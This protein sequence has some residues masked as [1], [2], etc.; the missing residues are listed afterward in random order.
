MSR[1]LMKTI[2]VSLT[3]S[4][5][6]AMFVVACTAAAQYADEGGGSGGAD[7]LVSRRGERVAAPRAQEAQA[8]S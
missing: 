6:T 5:C 7:P 4:L 8:R 1:E 2:G 3:S